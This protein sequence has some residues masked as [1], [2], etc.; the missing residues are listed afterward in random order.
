LLSLTALPGLAS[1]AMLSSYETVS[2]GTTGAGQTTTV[3]VPSG[4]NYGNTFSGGADGGTAVPTA[5]YGFYDDYFFEI[6]GATANSVTSTISLGGASG[7]QITG[8]QARLFGYAGAGAGQAPLGAVL[9]APIVSWTTVFS[10]RE[11]AVISDTVLAPGRYARQVR[12]TATGAPSS[13]RYGV[14]RCLIDPCGSR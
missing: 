5:I 4:V 14:H 2:T 7:L 8:L 1:A 12:G 3:P 10:S 9:P 13:S 6:T 11:L